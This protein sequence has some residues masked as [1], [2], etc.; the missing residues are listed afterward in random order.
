MIT[1]PR[2]LAVAHAVC[3]GTEAYVPLYLYNDRELSPFAIGMLTAIVVIFRLMASAVCIWWA[4][5]SEPNTHITL[6]IGFTLAGALALVG[7]FT[8]PENLAVL[9]CLM[10]ANGLFYQPLAA[11]VDSAIIKFLGDYKSW[12]YGNLGEAHESKQI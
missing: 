7:V 3:S 10:I 4:D 1:W 11:L 5:R 6:L 12:L 2:L 8:S 9:I